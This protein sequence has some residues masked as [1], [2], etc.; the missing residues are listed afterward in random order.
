MSIQPNQLDA[1][2]LK[3]VRYAMLAGLLIFGGVAYSQ[4]ANAGYEPQDPAANLEAIRWAGYGLCAAAIVG[5]A[6]LRGIRARAEPR[7]RLTWSLIGSSLAEG[8]ALV[9]AVLILL[10][11][12]IWVY[13]LGL[14]IFLG[15]WSLLPAD[16]EET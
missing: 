8:A 1:G 3:I 10:G 6:V 2:K 9:G 4:R 11:G 13:A 12:D 7:A 14:L 15:T 16:P 5:T